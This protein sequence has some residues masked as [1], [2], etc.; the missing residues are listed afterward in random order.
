MTRTNIDPNN[1]PPGSLV[2]FVQKGLQYLELEANLDSEVRAWAPM[3]LESA[4]APCAGR[5]ADG[6]YYCPAVCVQTGDVEG[7][8]KMLSPEELISNDI[9][10]LRGLVQERKDDE[11]PSKATER[12]REAKERGAAA[13]AAAAAA[14]EAAAAAAAAERDGKD[15]EAKAAAAAPAKDK[16]P[17]EREK[18]SGPT[19]LK[20]ERTGPVP[21]EEDAPQP[22]EVP[23]SSVTTLNGHE[24]E[25]YICAWNPVEPL[26]ASG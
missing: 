23:S 2:T 15:K 25:V 16:E 26:L 6:G 24:S 11:K 19:S 1:V 8:F 5:S 9:D 14:R 13:A 21:M 12:K 7:E 4:A 22:I 3:G 18:P 20:A 17:K 10:Q